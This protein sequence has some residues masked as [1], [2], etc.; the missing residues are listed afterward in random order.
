MQA[1]DRRG[2]RRTVWASGHARYPPVDRPRGD[3]IRLLR[4]G[5]LAETRR[6]G[7]LPGTYSHSGGRCALPASASFRATRAEAGSR[8]TG[9]TMAGHGGGL[10]PR[11]QPDHITSVRALVEMVGGTFA[12]AGGGNGALTGPVGGLSTKSLG[13]GNCGGSPEQVR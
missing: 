8:R 13:P 4:P 11:G 3:V 12:G 6:T 1:G 2:P 5:D 7:S 9:A 10:V